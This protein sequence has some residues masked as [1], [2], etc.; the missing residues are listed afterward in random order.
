MH[1]QG[2]PRR[3]LE[4][5]WERRASAAAHRGV[6]P[7]PFPPLILFALELSEQ[8]PGEPPATALPP[9]RPRTAPLLSPDGT[10][11]PGTDLRRGEQESGAGASVR[12]P[13][14]QGRAPRGQQCRDAW[15]RVGLRPSP[16]G[17]PVQPP[18]AL[19]RTECDP[20]SQRGA[21]SPGTAAGRFPTWQLALRSR[22]LCTTKKTS[23][24]RGWSSLQPVQ[25][26]WSAASTTSA[27]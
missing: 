2:A 21:E 24:A 11:A 1:K 6:S 10:A 22:S 19:P 17:C 15:R 13:R 4:L 18:P 8:R 23:R 20:L 26:S 9:A 3:S 5:S 14:H 7:S 16:E 25:T 27:P 12:L